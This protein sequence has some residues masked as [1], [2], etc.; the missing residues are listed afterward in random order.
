MS[1][2]RQV[3]RGPSH[4]GSSEAFGL[5]FPTHNH[6]C[7]DQYPL[8]LGPPEHQERPCFPIL[9]SPGCHG[10][11]HTYVVTWVQWRPM[12][13]QLPGCCGDPCPHQVTSVPWRFAQ[14]TPE[15]LRP[16]SSRGPSS[17]LTWCHYH[18][19]HTSLLSSLLL[20]NLGGREK[21]VLS[22]IPC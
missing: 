12:S 5:P 13:F 21:E 14:E 18:T 10:G 15:G 3:W 4:R 16:F 7:H 6:L 11:S 22:S 19:H 20:A 2:P 8:I 9:G 1:V 17:V